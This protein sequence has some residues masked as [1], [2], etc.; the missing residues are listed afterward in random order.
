MQSSCNLNAIQMQFRCNS[1]VIDAIKE[2]IEDEVAI[3][4]T[5][6]AGWVG[7]VEKLKLEL[8]SAKLG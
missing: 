5:F 3:F 2:E 6:T 1:D 8:N 4:T 7:G